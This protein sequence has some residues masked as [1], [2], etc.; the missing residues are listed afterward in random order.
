MSLTN[1]TTQAGSPKAGTLPHAD[2]VPEC[3]P[4]APRPPLLAPAAQL[5][6]S[7]GGPPAAPWLPASPSSL[8]RRQVVRRRADRRLRGR[9]MCRPATACTA[10]HAHRAAWRPSCTPQLRCIMRTCWMPVHTRVH[11]LPRAQRP[12]HGNW[13]NRGKTSVTRLKGQS[14]LSRCAAGNANGHARACWSAERAAR[15]WRG[16][17]TE[18][19]A[20]G[21]ALPTGLKRPGPCNTHQAQVYRGGHLTK[22]CGAVWV[23]LMPCREC[24]AAPGGPRLPAAHGHAWEA[25]RFMQP[26]ESDGRSRGEARRAPGAHALVPRLPG[27]GGLASSVALSAGASAFPLAN[28]KAVCC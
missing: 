11:G 10:P 16:C 8:D 15:H 7:S 4:R 23:S 22:R 21:A 26:L 18:D 1:T 14:S 5:P 6:T 19:A 25:R 20:D 2:G 3:A 17:G 24:C 9:R 28:A 27:S 13:P 12:D